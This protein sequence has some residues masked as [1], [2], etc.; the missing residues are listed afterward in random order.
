MIW[1]FDWLIC[2]VSDLEV[3]GSHTSP[4]FGASCSWSFGKFAIK[5]LLRLKRQRFFYSEQGSGPVDDGGVVKRLRLDFAF[6]LFCGHK[7][8]H[9]HI[10]AA[11]SDVPEA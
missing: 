2:G 1:R 10:S 11:L 6:V 5:S 4:R 3:V 7:L 8:A 9:V